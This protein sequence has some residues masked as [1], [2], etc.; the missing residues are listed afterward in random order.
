[1]IRL[2]P[3]L[4]REGAATLRRSLELSFCK[5]DAQVGDSTALYSA[6]LLLAARQW[7][8]LALL[9][10]SLFA[11]TLELELEL[12]ERRELWSELGLP[13]ALGR[14]LAGRKPTPGAGR[15]MRFDLHWTVSGWQL[16][17]V[18]SDVP[19]GYT[20]AT[21][22]PR[23]LE[24]AI[25]GLS[26]AGDPTDAVVAALSARAAGG[27]VVLACAPG[28]MED[29]QVVA[30]LRDVLRE[31]SGEAEIAT[32]GQ[33]AWRDGRA[34]L[35]ARDADREIAVIF[36]FC[37]AEW[38][39]EL[40]SGDEW[41]C[42]L[43]GGRTPVT[44]WGASALT[45]SKRLPLVWDR[46]RANVPTWRQL[47]PETRA[48]RDAPWSRDDGWLLKSAYCNNG[49][50]VSIRAALSPAEWQRRA[51]RARL[52]PRSWLAQ[53]R[54]ETVALS[55]EVGALH[56]CIGVYVVDGRAAGAYA[57]VTRR[58]LIDFAAMD[59]ALLIYDEE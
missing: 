52:Q 50:T 37:Q 16:S 34:W 10:E 28:F 35:R 13:R 51:W 2:G 9:A 49:D 45:E 12:L 33:I 23:L 18:N 38:L 21:H 22:L 25:G 39:P 36:R 5:W 6:P 53:R 41:P 56:A 31:R 58:P 44:N 7:Q 48:L 15:V 26:M 20:E 3:A 30:Q 59:A 47:L 27:L 55:D 14:A 24:S 57:R 1:M 46:L 11:E 19:G 29:H 32:V 43:G 8:R 42:F 17:E 4:S 54:F 40:C